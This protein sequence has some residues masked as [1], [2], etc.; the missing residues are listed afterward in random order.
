MATGSV[1]Y[2]YRL[3]QNY[4]NPFNHE[5]RINF[6]LERSGDTKLIIYDIEGREVIR[7]VDESL[8]AGYHSA[9]WNAS[10]AA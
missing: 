10:S 5:T 2:D 4:P 1:R 3:Q 8:S 7:L 6:E 9:N